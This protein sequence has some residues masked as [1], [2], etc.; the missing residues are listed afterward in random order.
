MEKYAAAIC[1][2]V[3]VDESV[4]II[5]TRGAA[6]EVAVQRIQSCRVRY[7]REGAMPV[8]TKER[9]L[10]PDEQDIQ[11]AVAVIVQECAAVSNRL[12]DIMK[13]LEILPENLSIPQIEEDEKA[14]DRRKYKVKMQKKKNVS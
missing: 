13:S 7:V 10:R 6:Q 1:G 9:Q 3:D 12:Q 5:I 2:E 14:E 8:S 4:V 11:V